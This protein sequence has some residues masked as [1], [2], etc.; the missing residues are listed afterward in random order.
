M[1]EDRGQ[2]FLCKGC[3]QLC[4]IIGKQI[5]HQKKNAG[6]PVECALYQAC[7]STDFFF[8]FMA[9]KP[10]DAPTAMQFLGE[11]P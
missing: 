5:A 2:W 8:R 10:V 9:G 7:E 4:G 1:I 6:E 3:G 11:L